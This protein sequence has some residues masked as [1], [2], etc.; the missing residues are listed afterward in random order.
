MCQKSCHKVQT[1]LSSHHHLN[2]GLGDLYLIQCILMSILFF[3]MG[4]DYAYSVHWDKNT[5]KW[6]KSVSELSSNSDRLERVYETNY[7]EFFDKGKKLC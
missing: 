6:E 2:F 3:D 4:V 5:N 1:K 7:T